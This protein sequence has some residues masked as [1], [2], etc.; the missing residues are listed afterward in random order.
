LPTGNSMI[1]LIHSRD[2]VI[3][4]PVD[5][6]LI[7]LADIVLTR[8]AGSVYIHLVK[9]IEPAKRRVEIGNNRGGS[10][11][12]RVLIVCTGSPFRWPESTDQAHGQRSLNHAHRRDEAG[13]QGALETAWRRLGA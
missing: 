10:T 1:P 2:E 5:P 13:Q 4:A 6:H 11:V 9:A 8:V 3:V 7:E 12:G